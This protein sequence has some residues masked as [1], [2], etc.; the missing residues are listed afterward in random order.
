MPDLY[1]KIVSQSIILVLCLSLRL[2]VPFPVR[3]FLPYQKRSSVKPLI[4]RTAAINWA[5]YS[6]P[7]LVG[8]SESC[9]GPGAPKSQGQHQAACRGPFAT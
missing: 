7:R 6:V 5:C 1:L 4:I 3:C 2:T 8:R 9:I